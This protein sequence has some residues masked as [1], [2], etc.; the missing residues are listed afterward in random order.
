M[1]ND[2]MINERHTAVENLSRGVPSHMR[3]EIQ[4]GVRK[5]IKMGYI[6]P[7]TTSYGLQVSLNHH[8]I[9]EIENAIVVR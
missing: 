3:G 6:I 9:A 7:K 1:Y 4:S 5:L 8:M 2:R